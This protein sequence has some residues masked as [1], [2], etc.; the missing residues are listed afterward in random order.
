MNFVYVEWLIVFKVY[1]GNLSVKKCQVFTHLTSELG[2]FI[3]IHTFF[4]LIYYMPTGT[5]TYI[6]THTINT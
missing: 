1:T 5:L 4:A 2:T 6:T 3:N